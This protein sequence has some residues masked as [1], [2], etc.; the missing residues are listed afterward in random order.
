MII[1]M[2][3][4]NEYEEIRNLRI[5]WSRAIITR[6]YIFIPLM[7]SII[8]ISISQLPNFPKEWRFEFLVVEVIVVSILGGY[9]RLSVHDTDKA[10]VGLYGRMLELEKKYQMDIQTRYYYSHLREEYKKEI[11]R[12]LGLQK[13]NELRFEEF[14]KEAEKKGKDYYDLLIEQWNL[15]E[16]ESVGTRGHVYHDLFAISIVVF[17]IVIISVAINMNAI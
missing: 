7:L 13:N 15:H 17:L 9:W 11:W 4:P 14:K 5:L 12:K 16:H 2:A 3:M 1:E 6:D 8:A 10:I